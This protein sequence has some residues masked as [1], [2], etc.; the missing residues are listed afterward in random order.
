[1]GIR[2]DVA[3]LLLGLLM[4]ACAAPVSVLV[5]TATGGL[6]AKA[7]STVIRL[8]KVEGNR[9]VEPETVRSYLQFGVGDRYDPLRV[10]DSLKALFA[11]GLF[12][13]VTRTFTDTGKRSGRQRDLPGFTESIAYSSDKG[14]SWTIWGSNRFHR[15]APPQGH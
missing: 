4:L 8:I 11:T 7:Q 13:G 5:G 9:R 3:R 10:D 6:E 1:M 12:S 2:K 15:V 14:R